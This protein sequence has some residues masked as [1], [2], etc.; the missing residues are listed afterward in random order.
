MYEQALEGMS[1]PSIGNAAIK[2]QLRVTYA[3]VKDYSV[4]VPG[5]LVVV[6]IS[7][8]PVLS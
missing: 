8:A 6:F 2:D 7:S 4:Q 3:R 5:F 1:G